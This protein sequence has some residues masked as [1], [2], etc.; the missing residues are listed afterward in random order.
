MRPF[1]DE[2]TT[3]GNARELH[4]HPQ[5][6]MIEAKWSTSGLYL[7]CSPLWPPQVTHLRSARAG[8]GT[9]A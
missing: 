1:V 8:A 4:K 9:A 5:Q 7:H 2:G 6:R 3:E